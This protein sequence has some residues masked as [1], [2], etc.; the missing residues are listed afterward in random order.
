M[1]EIT[2]I[3][4][5]QILD[6][7]GIP[8]VEVDALLQDGTFGRAAVPSGASTGQHEAVE[9]RDGDAEAYHGQGVQEAVQNVNNEIASELTGMLALD[10]TSIDQAL[11][12]LD[13]SKNKSNLGANAI[14]A[15][16]LAVARA[17]ADF[18]ELPLFRYIGGIHGTT[19]LPIPLMNFING[20][21]HAPNKLSLQEFMIVPHGFSSFSESLQAGAETFQCLKQLLEEQ[22]EYTAVGDEG[23]FAPELS[24]HEDALQL[25]V[26]AIEQAGYDPEHEIKLAL[27]AA[28]N[29]FYQNGSYVFEAQPDNPLSSEDLIDLYEEWVETYPIFSIEDGMAE[30]DQEGWKTLTERLGTTVQLVGDDLFVTNTERIETGIR[31]GIANAVLVKPNQIGTLTETSEAVMLSQN[32]SYGTIISHRSGETEDTTIADLA[33]GMNCSQ[34]KTGG[35]SRSER[36]AKYNRLLRIEEM[37]ENTAIFA[38][39]PTTNGR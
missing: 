8:T 17:A 25:L 9:L 4:A 33:V 10:Q 28:A 24:T 21:E 15:S 32:N 6:S 35:V 2:A 36:T 18:M 5:R 23:G 13:G 39:S 29:E 19:R 26:Q 30:D 34:I 12:S 38:G 16:S 3:W 27:D 7:R 1:S 20:G 37:L 31:D 22:G 11:L 14:L